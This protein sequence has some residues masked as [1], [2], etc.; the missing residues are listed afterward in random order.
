ML[1]AEKRA[2]SQRRIMAANTKLMLFPLEMVQMLN[3][4][5]PPA[6]GEHRGQVRRERGFT[7]PA[8]GRDNGDDFHD[9]AFMTVT[10]LR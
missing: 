1:L 3:V 6:C 9:G 4:T 2:R 8:L 7:D 10:S 5:W